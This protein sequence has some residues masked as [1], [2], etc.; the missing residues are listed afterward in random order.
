MS[1]IVQQLVAGGA[2]SYF[3]Q[4]MF[5]WYMKMAH[6]RKAGRRRT[7]GW[8]LD[9]FR[10]FGC[11][12]RANFGVNKEFSQLQT[13]LLYPFYCQLGNDWDSH[14][15]KT[16]F[17]L[18]I[19]EVGPPTWLVIKTMS[20]SISEGQYRSRGVSKQGLVK[21]VCGDSP[22]WA[23]T[24]MVRVSRWKL[25]LLHDQIHAGTEKFCESHVL[26]LYSRSFSSNSD[27]TGMANASFDYGYP[28]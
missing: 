9:V 11:I 19:L 21:C 14:C 22:L 6:L 8:Q 17:S 7:L 2:G 12:A 16:S 20:N 3:V 28:R 23:L 25:F 18:S 24:L 4:T 5:A 1:C 27:K 10:N 26:P 15:F 13:F